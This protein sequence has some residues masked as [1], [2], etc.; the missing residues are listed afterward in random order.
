MLTNLF[1]SEDIFIIESTKSKEKVIWLL[2]NKIHISETLFNQPFMP[3]IHKR[4]F[5]EFIY[6]DRFLIKSS[7]KPSAISLNTGITTEIEV[8]EQDGR[9]I[10]NFRVYNLRYK[11]IILILC[12]ALVL[13]VPIGFNKSGFSFHFHL[14]LA[15][16]LIIVVLG[17]G[18][19]VLN[20]LNKE[21][22]KYFKNFL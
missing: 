11:M 8:V 17:I 7:Y 2:Q 5:G 21:Q 12:S 18:Y 1:K 3:D 20:T 14:I 16:I 9:T 15:L 6:P 22:Q 19:L 4:Y 10:I 13:S